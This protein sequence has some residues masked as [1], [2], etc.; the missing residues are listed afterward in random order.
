MDWK[1]YSWN[2]RDGGGAG[3]PGFGRWAAANISGPDGNDY[4]TMNI[5]NAGNDPVGCEMFMSSGLGYGTYTI[6]V[7]KDFT[8]LDKNVVFGGLFPY[9]GGSPFIEFDVNEISA[10]DNEDADGYG[11]NVPY[12]SHN[13]WY[14]GGASRTH[15]S[16]IMPSDTV[17][18]HTLR[19]EPGIATYNS[20]I[21]TGTGGTLIKNSVH[22][23]NI[24]VPSSE[25]PIIN[26]WVYATGTPGGTDT[27]VPA[28]SVVLRDFYW[29][30]LTG[31]APAFETTLSSYFVDGEA[32]TVFIG[33]DSGRSYLTYFTPGKMS[34]SS[35]PVAAIDTGIDHWTE[36]E[37]NIYATTAAEN[38]STYEFRVTDNGT[39]L[40]TYSQTPRWTI[41]T[42]PTTFKPQTIVC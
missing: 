5:T 16:A 12:V 35:N 7:E 38:G 18:T 19:W 2:L 17:T 21:G 13:S 30:P 23:T 10:W 1:G 20:Y 9:F 34:E 24:P 32:T 3:G 8:T 6:V 31:S 39:P 11:A 37:W 36:V 28:T 15:T 26:L 14:N 41:G 4:I 40:N 22:N 29:V 27:D 25:V 33:D 42:T